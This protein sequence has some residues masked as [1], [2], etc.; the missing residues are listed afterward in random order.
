MMN[1]G[2][3]IFIQRCVSVVSAYPWVILMSFLA[4]V[5]SVL[6]QNETQNEASY[7]YTRL[8]FCTC[9]GIPMMLAI[10]LFR[11]KRDL[12]FYA[13]FIGLMAVVLFFF[14]F[15]TLEADFTEVY[16]FLLVPVYLMA[17]LLVSLASFKKLD[18]GLRFWQFNKSL[19]VNLVLTVLFTGV[20]VIG[21]LLAILAVDKL[22][23]FSLD[24][25]IYTKILF[26]LLI[27]G[28]CLI[29]LLFCEDGVSYLEKPSPF[30]TTL[31]FFTQFILIPLLL[32]YAVILYFYGGKIMIN[33]QLPM[34]WVGYLV[35]AYSILGILALLLVFPLK[36]QEAKSWVKIFSRVF[37]YTLIP[38]V[39]LLFIAIFT[40]IFAY[41]ITEAR[42]Y[43][44]MLAVWISLVG[45]YFIFSKKDH[46][47]IIPISLFLFCV[48]SLITPYF[49]VFSVAV[50]SQ[51]SELDKVLAESKL[52]HHHT[53][54]FNKT[55]PLSIAQEV[56]SKISFLMMR[57]QNHFLKTLI[58][59]S[60]YQ[61]LFAD[62][63]T[64]RKYA[65]EVKVLSLFKNTIKNN[66]TFDD[67]ISF[68]VSE[69]KSFNIEG[70]QWAVWYSDIG[71][72]G[73]KLGQDTLFL[74]PTI[75]ENQ[76]FQLRLATG[77]VVDFY[78][79]IHTRFN[80]QAT[81]IS[82][83]EISFETDLGTYHIKLIFDRITIEKNK[84][85]GDSFS[86]N[87]LVLIR[88]RY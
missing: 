53:I 63:P 73:L 22:F 83:P 9:L 68:I 37:Y 54:D 25:S 24:E 31:R 15:P 5:F 46:I 10:K 86:G 49:N 14:I 70:Y 82:Q 52:L 76:A 69:T 75:K 13:D 2:F 51:K 28:S 77:E 80:Q 26:F 74:M 34:G 4:A 84:K 58:K 65:S 57:D 7:C 1:K 48:V 87:P 18:D 64:K 41:G 27:F 88:K 62:N 81:A 71:N 17:H 19:F 6:A 20:M 85:K 8:I 72:E 23:D 59:D 78:Q 33:W 42:Y 16:I 43:V 40:R 67:P 47:Q 66:E 61:L 39:V 32:I 12:G 44:F 3:Q 50:R 60:D 56:S 11:Q 35:L 45:V 21:V 55:I 36:N 29:F 38:L 79:Q 30:P